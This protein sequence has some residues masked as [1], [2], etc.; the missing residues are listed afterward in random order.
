MRKMIHQGSLFLEQVFEWLRSTTKGM[1]SYLVTVVLVGM[2]SLFFGCEIVLEALDD[3]IQQFSVE[4]FC[5]VF[6]TFSAVLSLGSAGICVGL[7]GE[8]KH[9]YSRMCK[10]VCLAHL[11]QTF[12]GNFIRL[13]FGSD[14]VSIIIFLSALIMPFVWLTMCYKSFFIGVELDK[15]VE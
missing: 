6:T 7:I 4:I 12:L 10:I 1:I 3:R 2:M 13:V 11:T 14:S 5:T 15:R 9:P 8:E